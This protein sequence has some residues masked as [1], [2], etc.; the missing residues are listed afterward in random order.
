MQRGQEVDERRG[1][2]GA[3]SIAV[4]RHISPTLQDLADDLVLGHMRGDGVECRTAHSSRSADG[5]AV[6][7]LLVLQH[8]RTLP[9]E[10]ATV[11]Q[12]SRRNW[13]TGPGIHHGA[14]R[15]VHPEASEGSEN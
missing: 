9:L 4:R 5:V 8:E 10:R 7:A 3:E 2:G 14:P 1:L 13:I 15:R 11:F 12:I 6:T